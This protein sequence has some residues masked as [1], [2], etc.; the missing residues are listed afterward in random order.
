MSSADNNN[1]SIGNHNS[2]SGSS[3]EYQAKFATDYYID[4]RNSFSDDE[5]KMLSKIRVEK[6]GLFVSMLSRGDDWKQ[7]T[8]EELEGLSDFK[9]GLQARVKELE[10]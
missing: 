7:L 6:P 2:S 9:E 1:S 3:S 4:N 5:R 8:S 10:G